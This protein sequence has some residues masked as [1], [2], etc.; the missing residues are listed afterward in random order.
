[1][2]FNSDLWGVM[3]DLIYSGHSGEAYEFL[4]AAWPPARAGK[5]EFVEEFRAQLAS[6]PYV[7]GVEA[8]GHP[9]LPGR[10]GSETGKA[11]ECCSGA[12]E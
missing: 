12:S 8:L 6:S 7:A 1:M 11:P 5:R 2:D 10:V 4:E 3:L 9:K